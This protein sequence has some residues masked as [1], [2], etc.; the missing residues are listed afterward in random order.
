VTH[1]RSLGTKPPKFLA[2]CQ[3]P[4]LCGIRI[5]L[6]SQYTALIPSL[7]PYLFTD[8]LVELQYAQLY[9]FCRGINFLACY[10]PVIFIYLR[11]RVCKCVYDVIS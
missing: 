4:R 11:V 3:L 1:I 2:E 5:C 9:R 10:D 8:A 6:Y 7:Q